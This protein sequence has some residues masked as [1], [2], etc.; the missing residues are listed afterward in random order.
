MGDGSLVAR[1]SGVWRDLHGFVYRHLRKQG[2]SH[3]DAEDL[4]QD[5][6]E[7][8]Y[9][10]FDSVDPERR[11]AWLITVARNKIA[12]RA[13]RSGHVLTVAEMPE[14]ADPALG[15]DEIALQS[16]DRGILLRAIACLSE[17]D[18]RL[19]EIRYLE[20]RTVAETAQA[21]DMTVGAAK[22]GLHRARERLRITLETTGMASVVYGPSVARRGV[23]VAGIAERAVSAL[24]PYVGTVVAEL[25][26]RGVAVTL[27]KS[28]DALTIED[29]PALERRARQVLG[30]LL[31]PS[32][33]DR[34]IG[35]IRGDAQ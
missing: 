14:A 32:A 9:L 12:D 15:P 18:R 8:A 35:E 23:S 30:T 29:S 19:L 31:P 21:L 33:I 28:F 22:V 25:C 4:T 34:V 2:L 6:L 3:F 27:D 26:V 24:T 7:T 10:H 20:E 16:I 1:G 11:H 17:R 13:R 5:V